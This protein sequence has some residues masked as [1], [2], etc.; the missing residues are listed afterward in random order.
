VDTVARH[1]VVVE[2]K[3]PLDSAAAGL[4]VAVVELVGVAAVVL[5]VDKLASTP[6]A[7]L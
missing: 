1:A 2:R 7:L 6:L 3:G 4:V 5:R